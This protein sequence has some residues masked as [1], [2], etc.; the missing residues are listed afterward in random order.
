VTVR[1]ITAHV[2][3]GLAQLAEDSVDCVVTDPP[4]GETSLTWDK[5]VDGWLSAVRRVMKAEASLWCFGS[6]RFF[7]ERSNDFRDWHFAQEVVWEKHNGTGLFNDRF[8]RVHEL[9]CQFYPINVP[10]SLI[11]K[12]PL[13]MNDATA[14]VVRRKG[15][16]AQW[17]GATGETVYRSEDGGPRLMRSVMWARSEHGRA[18]HPTQKP[19]AVMMPLVEYSCPPGGIVL[20]PF[21]GSG[22]VGIASRRLGC[23]FIGIEFNPAYAEMAER[24]IRNDSGLFA[25]VAAE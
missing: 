14:R 5:R 20:D 6:M 17:I 1:I 22:V 4:Y 9:A 25:E 23:D 10:W 8:R 15:R 24:R 16:P 11:Y 2:L 7:M 19:I 3:D 21:C 13:F 18:E 12:K